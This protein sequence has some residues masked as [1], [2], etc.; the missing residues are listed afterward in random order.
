M[1]RWSPGTFA[2]GTRF[3][4]TGV[5]YGACVTI[6]PFRSLSPS[7]RTCSSLLTAKDADVRVTDGRRHRVRIDHQDPG[8]AAGLAGG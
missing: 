2:P 1:S 8:A 4:S 6:W 3:T 5:V 7:A